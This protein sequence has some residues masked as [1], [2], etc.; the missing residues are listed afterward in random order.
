MG[1]TAPKPVRSR[2][3]IWWALGGV[4]LSLLVVGGI[5]LEQNTREYRLL[6]EFRRAAAAGPIP[7]ELRGRLLDNI[8]DEALLRLRARPLAEDPDPRVRTALIDCLLARAT[9]TEL[10]ANPARVASGPGSFSGSWSPPRCAGEREFVRKLLAD[11]DP[12]VRRAAVLGWAATSA[13]QDYAEELLAA[14]LEP[15]DRVV[16]YRHAAGF[17]PATALRAAADPKLPDE[18]RLAVLDGRDRFG[19][20]GAYFGIRSEL[21]EKEAATLLRTIAESPNPK[22]R[23]A[24][25]RVIRF[26][27]REASGFWLGVVTTGAKED[28]AAAAAVWVETLALDSEDEIY[29]P[30]LSALAGQFSYVLRDWFKTEPGRRELA[31]L[32]YVLAEAAKTPVRQLGQAPRAGW[33]AALAERQAGPAGPATAAFALELARC[34]HVLRSLYLIC[35]LGNIEELDGPFTLWLPGD[36]DGPPAPR[37]LRAY[38]KARAAPLAAWC[39]EHADD[40]ASPFLPPGA[41]GPYQMTG[42]KKPGEVYTLGEVADHFGLPDRLDLEY[43]KKR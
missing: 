19:S 32:A 25:F 42:W 34:K 29:T 40:Y 18:L 10:P 21:D 28:A 6:R 9:R 1:E 8:S 12:G 7:D 23:H 30:T 2:R 22:V 43:W 5:A 26:S 41:A 4:V 31:A 14:D 33:R 20:R 13:A 17:H 27:P 11:P 38:L 39:R 15:A 35:F 16:V 37:S 24:A 36:P 3:L